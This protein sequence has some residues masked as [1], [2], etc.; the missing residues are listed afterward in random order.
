MTI[1]LPLFFLTL[2]EKVGRRGGK[3]EGELND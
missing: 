2:Y 1:E 3:K